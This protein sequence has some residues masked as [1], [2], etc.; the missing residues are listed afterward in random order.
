MK[1]EDILH[2]EHNSLLTL[3]IQYDQKNG[4]K[5]RLSEDRLFKGKNNY[6]NHWSYENNKQEVVQPPSDFT[7]SQAPLFLFTD[8]T[9]DKCTHC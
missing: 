6:I 3:R 4:V 9:G 8:K 5:F 7:D 1:T 2:L